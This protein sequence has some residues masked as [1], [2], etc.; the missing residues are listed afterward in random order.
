MSTLIDKLKAFGCAEEDLRKA[1]ERFLNNEAFYVRCFGKYLNDP[2]FKALGECIEAN[3]AKAV[4]E[5]AHT[6]KGVT[7]NMG[8]S[9][10]YEE[11]VIIVEAVR[12]S[13]ILPADVKAHYDK[14]ME[15]HAQMKEMV[16]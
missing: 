2:S 16:D 3:E 6:L 7:S 13:D 12:G 5:Q 14:I 10:V 9:P 1:V 8:I 11:V 15:Y 4:F